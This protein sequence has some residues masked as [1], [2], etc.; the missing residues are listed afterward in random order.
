MDACNNR[1]AILH[2]GQ[3]LSPG[4]ERIQWAILFYTKLGGKF[5]T[6]EPIEVLR[7]QKSQKLK[8]CT[9]ENRRIPKEF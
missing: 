2:F 6:G 4:L 5:H 8:S 9:E 7:Y 3:R 1:I